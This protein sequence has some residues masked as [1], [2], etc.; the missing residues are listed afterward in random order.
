ML[1]KLDGYLV[2]P[3]ELLHV[4]A[5]RL[6]GKRC[7]YR[8]GDHAVNSLEER[9]LGQ[10]LFCLLFPL[11][12]NSLVILMFLVPWF[13]TYVMTRYPLNP[14]EYFLIAP[15]WHKLLFVGW[16]LSMLYASSCM[17]DVIFAGRLLMKKLTQQP[18]E[19]PRKDQ[20]NRKAPQ[21]G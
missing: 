10:R 17:W 19:N 9:T 5:Y 21:Q 3:H 6:I 15:L 4:L 2:I 18:P 14:L 8:L 11:L 12:V 16:F 20:Y 7:V 1:W 13:V